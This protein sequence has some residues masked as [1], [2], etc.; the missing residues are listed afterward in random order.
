MLD[1][2]MH[3]IDRALDFLLKPKI[4]LF[5]AWI[6]LGIASLF[7]FFGQE[8]MSLPF[9]LQVIV[10]TL[11]ARAS[12]C[13]PE[14]SQVD[15][16]P[17]VFARVEHQ[18]LSLEAKSPLEII[19]SIDRDSPDLIVAVYD[20]LN[21]HVFAPTRDKLMEEIAEDLCFSWKSYV[22]GDPDKLTVKAKDLANALQEHF[23]KSSPA[24]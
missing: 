17:L 14:R 13:A 2:W 3:S 18:G 15:L 24:V 22:E 1:K 12:F 23:T 7:W 9:I 19:P 8:S 10:C 16:S 21:L 20:P 5:Q 11:L 4:L 6:S